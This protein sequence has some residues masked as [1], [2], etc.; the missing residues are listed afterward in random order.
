METRM[1][2]ANL[3]LKHSKTYAKSLR[4]IEVGKWRIQKARS[5]IV[6]AA[7]D[8]T[9]DIALCYQHTKTNH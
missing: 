2:E 6:G 5:K 9:I 4:L 8:L 7:R 1:K 3:E